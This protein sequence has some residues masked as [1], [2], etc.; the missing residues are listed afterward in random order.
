MH[1]SLY[2]PRPVYEVL[3]KV[4]YDERVKIHDLVVEG[5]DATLKRRRYP[6]TK[7]LKPETK[8]HP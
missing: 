8:R 1:T 3:R 7:N 2:L 4:A 6:S 5:I